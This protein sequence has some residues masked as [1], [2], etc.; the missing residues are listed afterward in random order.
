MILLNW[1]NSLLVA[2]FRKTVL[3]STG[4]SGNK[5]KNL[6]ACQP[7][8][9]SLR[10]C[11]WKHVAHNERAATT[12]A[13]WIG[14]QK[15]NPESADG[16]EGSYCRG[17]QQC[18]TALTVTSTATIIVDCAMRPEV[19]V[20]PINVIAGTRLVAKPLVRLSLAIHEG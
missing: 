19:S 17:K 20:L 2:G 4:Y 7:D 15:A 1:F 8:G 10:S 6:S 16:A 11:W 14:S 9:Q 3:F 18:A 5:N 12:S 13:L